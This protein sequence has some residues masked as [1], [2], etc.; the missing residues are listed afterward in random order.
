MLPHL[1]NGI[2]II[3]IS[4]FTETFFDFP[5]RAEPALRHRLIH[6]AQC[7][8]DRALIW[9][10]DAKL[11]I[12]TFPPPHSAYV[13]NQ[14]G[15]RGTI[16]AAPAEPTT[17]LS[18]DILR[19]PDLIARIIDYAGPHRTIQLI[20]YAA[21]RQFLQLVDA[22]RTQH[23]LTVLTPETGTPD[24]LWLRDYV[25][26][27]A[28]F[29]VMASRWLRSEGLLPEGVVCHN[30]REAA[31]VAHWFCNRE[32]KCIVKAD[33]GMSSLGLHTFGPH[34]CITMED[35]LAELAG[36]PFLRDD[37][38]IAEEFI[39]SPGLVSPSMEYFVPPVGAGSPFI[40]YVCDQRF[41]GLGITLVVS[42]DLL[43]APWYRTMADNGLAVAERLQQMGYVGHFDIDAIVDRDGRAYLVELNARRTGGT[44]IHEFGQFAF[45]PRYTDQVALLGHGAMKSGSITHYDELMDA[46]GNLLYPMNGKPRGVVIS[47]AATLPQGVFGCILVGSTIEDATD[48]QEQ[49][50]DRL[51]R[52]PMTHTS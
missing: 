5:N 4:N 51:E 8:G 37:L 28:G 42:R 24:C 15:Y 32:R 36:D 9:L 18:L 33:N 27:K 49:M 23:N 21:T 20:P 35:I 22:L 11:V 30:Q 41:V 31:A 14:L 19:E 6:S 29:R 7:Q 43:E 12:T 25:D 44:H 1:N 34:H 3:V 46:L 2:P 52:Q 17:S 50:M 39:E 16:Y 47:A 10:G 40:T 13:Q 48:L 38:L 26:S 45:G